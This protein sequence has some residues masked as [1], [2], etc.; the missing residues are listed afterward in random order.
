VGASTRG[1]KSLV[2]SILGAFLARCVT[3]SI[4]R[5]SAGAGAADGVEEGKKGKGTWG[6]RDDYWAVLRYPFC[7]QQKK[8]REKGKNI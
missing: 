1:K 2:R 5:V 7:E 3:R 4:L 6:G 8:T